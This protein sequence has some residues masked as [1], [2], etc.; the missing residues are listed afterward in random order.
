MART[1]VRATQ[2]KD[3]QIKNLQIASDAAIASSKLADGEN[4]LKKDGSVSLTADWD[5]GSNKISSS[6]APTGDNHL[7]NKAYVDAARTG[8]TIKASVRAAS[9]GNVNVSSPGSSI[10]GV[11]LSNGDRV[12]LRAQTTGSQNGIYV[13]NGASSAMTRATDADSDAE[14]KGGLTVWVNEGDTYGDTRHVLTTNDSI[15][16]G[17]T[18]LTFS[19]DGGLANV[20]AGDGLTKSGNTLAVGAGDGIQVNINSVEVKLNGSTLEKSSSG[21]K[22][23]DGGIDTA[24][25]GT[26]AVTTA[27]IATG[28]VDDTKL[29]ANSVTT[30][31][32]SDGNVTQAKLGSASV[33]TA[34]LIDAN[35]TAAKLASDSV[36][37][38]KVADSAI[39]TA[40]IADANVTTGKLADESVTT[41]KLNDGAVTT[42]KITDGN[43]TS[44]KLASASVTTAKIDDL[45]VTEAK[46]AAS[47][48]AT[49]KIADGAVTT[50]K[51][52]DTAV[53]TAKITDANVTAAKL[54]TDSVTT[55]KIV[56]GNVTE[57]KLADGA[58]A[59][60]KVQDDAITT[61]KIADANVTTDKLADDSVTSDKIA[62]NAVGV[63]EISTA[64]AGTGLSGGGGSA[65]SVDQ[66]VIVAVANVIKRET[67]SGAVNS[68]NTTF[69]IANA[70]VSGSEE[71]YL[72]GILQDEGASNDYTM[73]DSETIEFN[74][75][76]MTGDKVRVSYLKA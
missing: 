59:T 60:D 67:P 36:I 51:L 75:P 10:D 56:N 18:A 5:I 66:S 20:D 63:S 26:G 68:S 33:G 50:A 55:A 72:N 6:A 69:T 37:T 61:A 15:I 62:A 28:A 34:Q 38:A 47:A 3:G 44:A 76:P 16:L 48:V 70:S 7:V 17:T 31:K 13:F 11:S 30:A 2:L 25:L 64:I 54:A 19:Q 23:S 41:A 27:K 45:A 43:V 8:L 73:T 14:V 58:V 24:Q 71:V 52:A 46:L 49:A 65:L 32:I 21:L 1:Q 53:T 4:F 9:T 40:K 35:V 29:A 12:L 42:A 74:D 22:V 39:T 57:A